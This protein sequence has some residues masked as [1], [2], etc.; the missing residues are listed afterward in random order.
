MP[1]TPRWISITPVQNSP[2]VHG[3][4]DYFQE[5]KYLIEWA[6]AFI[7]AGERVM[8]GLTDIATPEEVPT[9]TSRLPKGNLLLP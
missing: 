5:R 9:K 4:G 8:M 2:N 7:T 6:L 1:I 3:C